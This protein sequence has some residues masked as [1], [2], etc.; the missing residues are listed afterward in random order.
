VKIVDGTMLSMPDTQENQK[1]WPQSK[2][3]KEGCGF[4]LMK[5]VG[6]FSLSSGSLLDEVHGDLHQHEATLFRALWGKLEKG[7]IVLEDRGFCSFV[8][9]AA[10]Q[11]KGVD[12]VARLHQARLADFRRGKVLGKGDRLVAWTKPLCCPKGWSREEFDALPQT[13]AVRL[14]RLIVETPGYR[15]RTVVLAT[16]LTDADIY[17][18]EELRRLYAQ[19]WNIEL[20]YAQI[21]TTLGMDT[22]RC[23]SPEMIERELQ[24]NLIAYN[25]V[26]ALM[27]RAAHTHRADLGRLSFK[28]SLDTLRHWATVIHAAKDQPRKQQEL[29]SHLLLSIASDTVPRRPGRSE[30]RAK[31]R[32]PKNFQLL[33]KPRHQMGNLPHRNR[34]SQNHHKTPLS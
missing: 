4:P 9:M 20:H 27:Q 30:P 8:A 32:R 33:T 14:I 28:G 19:R 15:T 29:I 17:P 16:T 1:A 12:T 31:K 25:F 34:P 2:S 11:N 18:A 26:R 7:D 10:L 21:K 24:L 23:K 5:L 13:L 6:L 3:Q 22:L